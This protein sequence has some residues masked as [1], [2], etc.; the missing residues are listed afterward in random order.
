MKNTINAV[1]I[2]DEKSQTCK[3]QQ[4]AQLRMQDFNLANLKQTRESNKQQTS[5]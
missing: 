4:Q 5:E 2:V 1:P 3:V